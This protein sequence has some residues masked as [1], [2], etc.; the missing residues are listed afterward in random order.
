MRRYSG[1]HVGFED[2]K[3]FRLAF[4]LERET[5]QA[6]ILIINA[7]VAFSVIR[8]LRLSCLMKSAFELK[9]HSCIYL[10]IRV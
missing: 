1:S 9:H 5:T 4:E 3:L 10:E 6:R 8:D 7:T 2:A